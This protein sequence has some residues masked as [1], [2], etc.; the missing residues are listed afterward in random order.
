MKTSS[1][2]A[3]RCQSCALSPPDLKPTAWHNQ[4]QA[5]HCHDP[6]ARVSYW[7][8]HSMSHSIETEGQERGKEATAEMT[9]SSVFDFPLLSSFHDFNILLE[10][11][12]AGMH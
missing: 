5:H 10:V 1:I 6:E 9:A 11:L 8:S 2:D 3:A 12:A 4:S 7:F